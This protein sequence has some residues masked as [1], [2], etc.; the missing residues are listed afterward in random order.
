MKIG[1][2]IIN[3][4]AS[5]S[6]TAIDNTL[7]SESSA[8]S[9]K[10]CFRN[11]LALDSIIFI[12]CIVFSK[13][14]V[15]WLKSCDKDVHFT[16]GILCWTCIIAVLLSYRMLKKYF[17]NTITDLSKDSPLIN[18]DTSLV[19]KTVTFWNYFMC[20]V[21]SVALA[22][23][24]FKTI[25]AC[26][27]YEIP[28]LI[29][30]SLALCI[31]IFLPYYQSIKCS[32]SL[33]ND[34]MSNTENNKS[35]TNYETATKTNS[36]N[37]KYSIR[38]AVIDY[39]LI[40]YAISV[41]TLISSVKEGIDY[42]SIIVLGMFTYVTA[43]FI[44]CLLSGFEIVMTKIETNNKLYCHEFI[45]R[46]GKCK[47]AIQLLCFLPFIFIICFNLGSSCTSWCFILLNV[48]IKTVLHV[49]VLLPAFVYDSL[50]DLHHF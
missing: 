2:K 5:H 41:F 36:I 30:S 8:F 33:A 18:N 31:T 14:F 10:K 17:I 29:I 42:T 35:V 48:F 3:P 21:C 22:T 9:S 28:L 38:F 27:V 37:I 6:V 40:T 11:F 1:N 4:L 16:V 45:S 44:A 34:S 20:R 15:H 12:I 23:Y 24:I 49:A 39:D 47:I 32:R 26:S 50:N 46:Y 19:N 43:S 13:F 25:A 7:S